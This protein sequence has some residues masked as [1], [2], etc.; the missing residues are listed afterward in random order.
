MTEVDSSSGL[1]WRILLDTSIA[2]TQGERGSNYVQL[3]T[4]DPSGQP[5]NR[6]IVFRGFLP[7][8]GDSVMSFITDARADK[9]AE[10]AGNPRGELV[11][12][13]PK[14]MEQYR[15]A[16]QL[17]LV[18]ADHPDADLRLARLDQWGNWTDRSRETMWSP[19]PGAP[20]DLAPAVVPP[21]GGRDRTGQVLPP[22]D[23][24]LLL[25]LRPSRTD[26]L[27]LTD[28]FRQVYTAAGDVQRPV[29]FR[30]PEPPHSKLLQGN[31][32]SVNL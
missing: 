19:P 29:Q 17:E 9:V 15:I 32:E 18:G 23:N 26:Y 4:V 12:W 24:F 14:R 10:V 28:N 25:L 1:D 5:H 3:A 27:R 13:F 2:Q 7:G 11:W 22:P 30:F 20:H 8:A 21:S 31:L 16:G 6:T